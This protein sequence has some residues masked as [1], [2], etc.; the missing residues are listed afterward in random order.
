MSLT[1]MHNS[2]GYGNCQ[3]GA[4]CFWLNRLGIH[5]S[6]EKV[7]E[8]IVEYLE[9][10][11]SDSKGFPLELHAGV[12][13]PYYLQSMATDGTYGDQITLQAAADLHNIEVLV[14]STL[15]HNVTTLISPSASIPYARVHLGHYSEQHGEHYICVEG[16]TSVSEEDPHLAESYECNQEKDGDSLS[17]QET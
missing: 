14:V 6:P 15:G 3:F 8:E 2:L 7:R 11:P 16:G 4:L 5:R 1:L 12:P 10:N 13:W 9:N 17:S